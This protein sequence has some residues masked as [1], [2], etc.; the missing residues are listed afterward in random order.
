METFTLGVQVVLA[1]VFATAGIAKL[2]DRPG[3]RRALREFGVPERL[4]GAGSI[5]LPLGELLTAVALL[6]HGTARWGA[7]AALALLVVFIGAILSALVRGDAPD[8]HCFGQIHSEPAGKA[9][10]ARNLVLAAG[11]AFVAADGPG[12]PLADWIAARSTSELAATGAGIAAAILAGAS[13]TLWRKARRL[14]RDLDAARAAAAL[15]PPGLPLGTPAPGFVL[16]GL[17][18]ETL[19]LDSLRGRGRPVALVFADPYCGPCQRLL[20][21]IGRWQAVMGDRLTIAVVSAGGERDNRPIAEEHGVADLLL[22]EAS[23]VM[24]TYRIR[25][26]PSALIVTADG[27]IASSPSEGEFEIEQLVRLTLQRE[28]EPAPS[29]QASG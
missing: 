23:E 21:D 10:L 9:T 26:T 25:L 5:V 22:Q 17:R 15:L 8:C 3:S 27:H 28:S 16:P 12:A 20:P 14:R 2:R 29:D 24:D 4:A 19:T 1:A 11:A 7:F 6:V 13:V 18:G